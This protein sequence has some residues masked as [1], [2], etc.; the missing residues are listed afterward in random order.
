MKQIPA[1]FALLI[2]ACC[3][4]SCFK[5][6]G[7]Y[8]FRPI[9]EVTIKGVDTTNGYV[10]YFGQSLAISPNIE[11]SLD[12]GDATYS[13]EWS[14]ETSSKQVVVLA[15][16]KALNTK[17][18][19]LPGNY[20]IFYRV[21]D[22][23]SGVQYRVSA[24]LLISSEVYEGYLVLNDVGG[25]S[26][27][28]MLS[29]K[30]ENADFTQ[31]TDVLARMGSTL[32]EQGKPLMVFS[33]HAVSTSN[34]DPKLF[35]IYLSTASG[36][37]TIDSET[38]GYSETNNIRYE[39]LGDVPQQFK[40]EN[41]VGSYQ[42]NTL[43]TMYIYGDN[44]VFIRRNNYMVF[45]Y[46]KLNTYAGNTTAFKISPYIAANSSFVLMYNTDKR[47]FTR[48]QSVSST[49]AFDLPS[50]LN[51]PTGKDLVYMEMSY[52]GVVHAILKDPVNP[53]YS[54]IRFNMGTAPNYHEVVTATDFDQASHFAIS[55]DRGYL[56][57]SVRG[58]VYEYDLSLK[59]TKLMLDK[60]TNDISY[61]AFPN[62]FFRSLNTKYAE[63]SQWLTVGAYPATGSGS[64]DGTLEQFYVPPV[65]GALELRKSW[66]GFGK[67]VSIAYRERR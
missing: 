66:T 62:F 51:Y 63:W 17:V 19:L 49:T 31:Y 53:Q 67:I 46:V 54:I 38:F 21:T 61:L 20:T 57:Y 27:L 26:R 18:N 32:P 3:I 29:Y 42:A 39:M 43:P 10:A 12:K 60:G 48:T 9:N 6:K 34:T 25:K 52:T 45:P 11:G 35:R 16:T 4:A 44:G 28:D 33:M 58:K 14:Y 13:Y 47:I 50:N 1:Y 56:F 41:F 8:N 36:T 7:N 24:P 64:T 55:P 2:I 65:N 5:D 22:L 23:A 40:V 30:K 15:D 59:T 37:N